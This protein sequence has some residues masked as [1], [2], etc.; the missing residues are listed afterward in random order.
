MVLQRFRGELVMLDSRGGGSAAG[1]GDD[2]GGAY[3]G[4]GSALGGGSSRAQQRP[5]PAFDSELDDDVPF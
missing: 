4:G 2:Y 5:A 1:A 3:E